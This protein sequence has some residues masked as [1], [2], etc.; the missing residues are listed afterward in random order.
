MEVEEDFGIEELPESPR[1]SR[2]SVGIDEPIPPRSELARGLRPLVIRTCPAA[3]AFVYKELIAGAPAAQLLHWNRNLEDCED[4]CTQVA[5]QHPGLM[6]FLETVSYL[7]QPTSEM[8]AAPDSHERASDALVERAGIMLDQHASPEDL[9]MTWTV[10][11]QY[12]QNTVLAT[13]PGEDPQAILAWSDS[14]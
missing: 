5:D 6:K 1:S 14:H 10:V 2:P 8:V 11:V 3:S 13:D 7:G 9:R 4:A 12:I